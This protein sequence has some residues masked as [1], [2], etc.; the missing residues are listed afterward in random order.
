[1]LFVVVVIIMYYVELI[2]TSPGSTRGSPLFIS[3]N[4]FVTWTWSRI[5][6]LEASQEVAAR[7][8]RRARGTSGP[9]VPDP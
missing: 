5:R 6:I 1:M 3:C 4:F 7:Y 8:A 9:G 2:V